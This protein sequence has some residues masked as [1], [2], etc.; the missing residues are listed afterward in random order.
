MN[1]NALLSPK[2]QAAFSTHPNK[3]TQELLDEENMMKQL[4]AFYKKHSDF[5][6]TVVQKSVLE[7][8]MFSK[9]RITLEGMMKASD[10][11]KNASAL[12]KREVEVI[13]LLQ[14][15][16][17]NNLVRNDLG[18]P[19]NRKEVEIL[20]KWLDAMLNDYVFSK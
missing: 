7:S 17:Q 16:E 6:Y 4:H 11:S 14:E 13:N 19:T 5:N 2:F 10:R 9:Q 15:T 18:E 12:S 20:G 1:N 3:T 8:N